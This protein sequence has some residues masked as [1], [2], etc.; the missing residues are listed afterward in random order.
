MGAKGRKLPTR[1]R[2]DQ[3]DFE[4]ARR[5]LTARQL[6]RIANCSEATLSRARLGHP[7]NENT[8]HKIT[9]ALLQVPVLAGSDALLAA[10][11]KKEVA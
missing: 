1:I 9:A 6:A 4:R 5:G 7:I 11:D 8:L 2:A 3:L 10:P